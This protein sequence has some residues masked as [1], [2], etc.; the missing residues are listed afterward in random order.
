MYLAHHEA[1]GMDGL[2]LCKQVRQ[3]LAER[4]KYVANQIKAI[5]CMLSYDIMAVSVALTCSGSSHWIADAS[6]L[7]SYS[8]R[9]SMLSIPVQNLSQIKQGS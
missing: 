1:A 7:V 6:G 9:I 3:L 4:L 8:T 5:D 2:T